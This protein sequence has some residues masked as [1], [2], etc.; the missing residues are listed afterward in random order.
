MEMTN[1]ES[2]QTVLLRQN[3]D[4]IQPVL[5]NF[6][7]LHQLWL[8]YVSCTGDYILTPKTKPQNNFCRLIRSHPEGSAKM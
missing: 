1:L 5:D 4:T 6:S 3:F 8:K 2:S 7:I